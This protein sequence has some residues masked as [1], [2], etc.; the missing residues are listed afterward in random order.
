MSEQLENSDQSSSV[1]QSNPDSLV[2]T[3]EKISAIFD[4]IKK[5]FPFEVEILCAV[6]P[7]I[8]NDFFPSSDILTKVL[9]EFLSPQQPHPKLLSRVVFKVS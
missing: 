9:G 7:D 4:R 1:V 8:L 3:I 2:Q 6:L 5:G